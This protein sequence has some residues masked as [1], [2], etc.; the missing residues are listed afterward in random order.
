MQDEEATH[1]LRFLAPH[2]HLSSPFGGDRFGLLAESFA[3]TF[4]T[5]RLIIVQTALVVVWIRPMRLGPSHTAMSTALSNY[6]SPSAARTSA[7]VCSGRTMGT[8]V[9]RYSPA[10]AKSTL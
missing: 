9:T 2:S 7:A 3:R 6:C 8:A 5:P 1:H 10:V 4:G